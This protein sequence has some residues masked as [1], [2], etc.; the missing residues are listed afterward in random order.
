MG[1]HNPSAYARRCWGPDEKNVLCPLS[2]WSARHDSC[3][4]RPRCS[5]RHVHFERLAHIMWHASWFV[6]YIIAKIK[7][8]WTRAEYKLLLICQHHAQ[9]HCKT[10]QRHLQMHISKTAF[11]N[12]VG[13]SAQTAMR[14]LMPSISS[15]IIVAVENSTA[16]DRLASFVKWNGTFIQISFFAWKQTQAL[17]LYIFPSSII[18]M[19]TMISLWNRTPTGFE[20]NYIHKMD[21]SSFNRII[22]KC[23]N[24]RYKI[25]TT[26]T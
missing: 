21:E 23:L 15:Q 7:R 14:Q 10:S 3:Q 18:D 26:T 22:F 1:D 4:N 11:K 25:K 24:I 9:V 16:S 17:Q 12:E 19:H 13:H 6:K 8:Q 20:S 2:G 5:H